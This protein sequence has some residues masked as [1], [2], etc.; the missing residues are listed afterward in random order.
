MWCRYEAD[1]QASTRTFSIVPERA[2]AAAARK[3]SDLNI[4]FC[5]A[6]YYYLFIYSFFYYK[7]DMYCELHGV[8]FST[9]LNQL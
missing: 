6:G 1:E 9:R 3:V 7:S 4:D 5:V 8:N 2:A